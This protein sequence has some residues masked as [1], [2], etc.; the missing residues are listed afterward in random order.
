MTSGYHDIVVSGYDFVYQFSE[1]LNHLK[2]FAKT[3]VNYPDIIKLFIDLLKK[4]AKATWKKS[5]VD[6]LKEQGTQ[7]YLVVF[8]VAKCNSQ[9][10][11]V[12]NI[13]FFMCFRPRLVSISTLL[14][15]RHC[16]II[17]SKQCFKQL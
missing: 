12:L 17:L 6:A 15:K 10:V 11:K 7:F 2:K 1:S 8:L 5:F 3:D 16:G 13:V 4:D 9:Y 14:P